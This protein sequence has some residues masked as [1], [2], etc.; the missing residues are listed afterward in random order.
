MLRLM[1]ACHDESDSQVRWLPTVV[2]AAALL[3]AIV[4]RLGGLFAYVDFYGDEARDAFRVIAI[5]HGE[6][7]TL[8][9]EGTH[10]SYRVPPL[11]YYLLA[12]A[13][14]LGTLPELQALPN[15]ICSIASIPLLAAVVSRLLAG[16]PRPRRELIVALAA[17]WWSLTYVDLFLGNREWNPGPIPCFLL[18]LVL[19]WAHQADPNRSAL[20]RAAT[21]AGIGV[22]LA[23]LVSTH[24][25]T[26]LVV[27]VAFVA[28]SVVH[29]ASG[30]PDQR[31]WAEPLGSVLVA[32]L[33]LTPYW[34]GEAARGWS[35]SRA[36][37]ETIMRGSGIADPG[38]IKNPILVHLRNALGGY[39]GLVSQF[40]APQA[41]AV[42]RRL[43]SLALLA[44]PFLAVLRFRGD[45][46][47]FVALAVLWAVFLCAASNV[48]L[49][50]PHWRLPL[51]FAPILLSAIV[52]GTPNRHWTDRASVAVVAVLAAFSLGANVRLDLAY[53]EGKFGAHHPPS[54]NDLAE[55]LRLLPYHA[56]VCELRDEH[57]D[58][59]AA[60]YLDRYV[61]RR[62]LT[63]HSPCR[64][65]NYLLLPR[66]AYAHEDRAD[67]ENN[68]YRV[69]ALDPRYP[70]EIL[71]GLGPLTPQRVA[72]TNAM[73]LLRLDVSTSSR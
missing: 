72:M 62:A 7:P 51:A 43:L 69:V 50:Y 4:T 25:S 23:L 57:G 10:V 14:L 41:P 65:G 45:R 8:G 27:P 46:R 20:D 36:I 47:A 2:F 71:T 31:R 21:S 29:V 61:I 17:L 5:H 53:L 58:W 39:V 37:A 64:A 1:E 67:Y 12:P 40:V 26:L 44:L 22:L 68:D 15:A 30:S 66:Y 59:E 34:I 16:V 54:A 24:Y 38:Q 11:Y 35:N 32:L 63:F 49:L 13:T 42:L 55:S 19:L 9:P 18:A 60:R 28:M 70:A 3:I 33:C 56:E 52:L 48:G 73:Q 6:W